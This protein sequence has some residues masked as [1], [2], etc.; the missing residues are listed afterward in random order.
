MATTTRTR[1]RLSDADFKRKA[2][3]PDGS[4][5]RLA[6]ESRERAEQTGALPHEL[7]LTWGRG[8]PMSRKVPGPESDRS[9]PTTWIIQY[10]P[11]EADD[12]RDCAK[13]AAPYFAPKITA[14][15]FTAGLSNAE[16]DQLITQFATQ[17]G[18]GLAAAGEG[19]EDEE[20]P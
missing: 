13:A 20:Q 15:E 6:R 3:R 10:I 19:E 5:N 18:L 17:A 1:V 9:D 11:M 7:L 2:G 14:I 8:E 16:L 4:I 12:M